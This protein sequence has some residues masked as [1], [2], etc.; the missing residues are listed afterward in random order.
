[1]LLAAAM[2]G[3]ASAQV[4][5]EAAPETAPAPTKLSVEDFSKPMG[6]PDPFNRGTP[7]DSMYGFLAADRKGEYE[8]AAEHR[9][10]RRLPPEDR[11]R[12]PQI[13]QQLKRVLDQT[14]WVD[15]T[16]LSDR[17]EGITAAVAGLGVGGI[18]EWREKGEL[19]FPQFPE[20][21]RR[22]VWNTL[23]WPPPGSPDA[24]RG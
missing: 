24:P 11:E 8:R 19:P 7:R 21:F 16:L 14:L 3:E 17:R 13:A 15:L 20:E 9:D 6:P 12:G 18:A 4:T 1:M 2:G 10:L 22:E 23:Q 5:Q